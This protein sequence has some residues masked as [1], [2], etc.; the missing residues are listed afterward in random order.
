MR[1]RRGAAAPPD[2]RAVRSSGSGTPQKKSVAP[3]RADVHTIHTARLPFAPSSNQ[4]AIS[5]TYVIER[6]SCALGG[7][8]RGRKNRPSPRDPPRVLGPAAKAEL[9]C[10][11]P[12]SPMRAFDQGPCGVVVATPGRWSACRVVPCSCS[13]RKALPASWLPPAL[14]VPLR[15]VVCGSCALAFLR[16]APAFLAAVGASWGWAASSLFVRRCTAALLIRAQ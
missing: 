11:F 1:G 5:Q 9:R 8:H 12:F 15:C 7:H 4:V 3:L 10:G 6:P 16:R 14:L 2:P 13:P